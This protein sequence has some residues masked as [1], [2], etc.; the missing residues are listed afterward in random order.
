MHAPQFIMLGLCVLSLITHTVNHGKTREYNAYYMYV[1][2][3]FWLL[4]LYWGGFFSH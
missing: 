4:L 3:V 2:T 1:D